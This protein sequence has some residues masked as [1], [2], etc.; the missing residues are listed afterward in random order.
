MSS[1]SGG[2]DEERV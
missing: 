2:T 1:M